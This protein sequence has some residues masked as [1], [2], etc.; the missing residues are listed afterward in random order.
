[1]NILIVDD[2]PTSRI[3][4][5]ATLKKSGHTVTAAKN[6]AEALDVFGKGNVPLIISD[7]VMSGVDGLELCRRIRAAERTPYTYII[8][9]TS[10][11][12]VAGKYGYLIGLKAGADDVISKPFDEEFLAAKLAVAER[13]SNLQPLPKQLDEL[14]TICSTCSKIRLDKDSWQPVDTYISEHTDAKFTRSF[15]PDC[16]ERLANQKKN[17][18]NSTPAMAA[19]SHLS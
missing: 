15:C 7:I 6:G 17:P 5:E 9:L 8:L 2:D 3:I 13:I 16:V 19:G 11:A 14:L 18:I 1:M 12:S 4:L 10:V